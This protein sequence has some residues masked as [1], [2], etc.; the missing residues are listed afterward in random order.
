MVAEK[1]G[2]DGEKDIKQT[3]TEEKRR[4]SEAPVAIRVSK[5]GEWIR[6]NSGRRVKSTKIFEKEAG[7]GFRIF[8]SGTHTLKGD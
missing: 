3:T 5:I 8:Q 1:W 2:V 6:P 4:E 7:V